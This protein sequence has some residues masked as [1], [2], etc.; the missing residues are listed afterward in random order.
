MEVRMHYQRRLLRDLLFSSGST[1]D[2]VKET[3]KNIKRRKIRTKQDEN[4]KIKITVCIFGISYEKGII[5]PLKPDTNYK[6]YQ[7]FTCSDN[8]LQDFLRN[9]EIC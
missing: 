5:Y 9:T 2:H 7:I 1:A 6:E 4:K 3:C 8:H